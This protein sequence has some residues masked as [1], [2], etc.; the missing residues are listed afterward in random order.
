MHWLSVLSV[1]AL[2]APLGLLPIDV[3]LMQQHFKAFPSSTFTVF[4]Y[5]FYPLLLPSSTVLLKNHARVLGHNNNFDLST[6]TTTGLA[7]QADNLF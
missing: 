5:D 3:L 6:V 7:L 4:T 1:T 2:A